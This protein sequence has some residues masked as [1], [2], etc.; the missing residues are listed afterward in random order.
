ML[1]CFCT[2]SLFI[3]AHSQEPTVAAGLHTPEL[4]NPHT[5]SETPE[6]T[7]GEPAVEEKLWEATAVGDEALHDATTEE[8]DTP[9]HETKVS[10]PTSTGNDDFQ[11]EL[12][13]R[14]LH[15]GDIYASF[16]FR[17]LWH[18]DFRRSKGMLAISLMQSKPARLLV[19]IFSDL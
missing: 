3:I 16:Q 11:E 6:N 12:V 1:L 18:T 5:A 15:S 4:E 2:L 19:V 9:A 8:Q 7:G 17:T 13:I 14:P 10:P